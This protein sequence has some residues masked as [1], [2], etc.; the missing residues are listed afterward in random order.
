[1][2]YMERPSSSWDG[3]RDILCNH[4]KTNNN[5]A[6]CLFHGMYWTSSFIRL[7]RYS[8]NIWK[9]YLQ[10]R[11]TSYFWPLWSFQMFTGV[12]FK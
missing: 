7:R 10:V 8:V 3:A 4:N 5:E 1:M 11:R 9:K 12:L 2:E 6:M